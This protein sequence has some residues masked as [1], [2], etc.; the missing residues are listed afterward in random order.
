M[1]FLGSSFANASGGHIVYGMSEK[2]GL[3]S[4]RR[5]SRATSTRAVLRL[6]SMARNGIRPPIS[7]LAFVCVALANGNAAI[8][9]SKPKSW[10]PPRQDI[11]QKDYRTY[12]RGSVGKQHDHPDLIAMTQS[13]RTGR[14]EFKSPRSDQ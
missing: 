10:N 11:F 8:I 12:T 6:E 4:S 1:D 9:V 2:K 5:A 3:P 7:G 14:R 13:P